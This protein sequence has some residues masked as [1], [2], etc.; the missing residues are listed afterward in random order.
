M[1]LVLDRRPDTALMPPMSSCHSKDDEEVT[2]AIDSSMQNVSI[3][4]RKHSLL[5]PTVLPD[6]S[7]GEPAVRIMPSRNTR[8]SNPDYGASKSKKSKTEAAD[9]YVS[10]EL[11]GE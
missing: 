7:T 10:C 3:P 6:N 11:C 5:P 2:R 8:N 9:K 4:K 1:L